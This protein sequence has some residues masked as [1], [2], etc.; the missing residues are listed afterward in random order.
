[1]AVN[2]DQLWSTLDKI[3]QKLLS[4][5]DDFDAVSQAA[6]ALGG[7]VAHVL[8]VQLNASADAVLNLVNGAGQN[9]IKNLKDYV[10]NIPLGDLRTKSAGEAIRNGQR[11]APTQGNAPT[12]PAIDTTPHVGDAPKSAIVNEGKD[13]NLDDYKKQPMKESKKLNENGEFSFDAILDEADIDGEGYDSE[14]PEA[15]TEYLESDLTD[16]FNDDFEEENNFSFDDFEAD[17]IASMDNPPAD[18]SYEDAFA[19]GEE[20]SENY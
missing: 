18:P 19:F 5:V 6:V 11:E 7:N 16:G 15:D 3:E 2:P 13:I 8:P 9:S 1:M 20:F 4:I 10:D 17:R 14:I 12:A